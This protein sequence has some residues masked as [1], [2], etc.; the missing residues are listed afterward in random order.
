MAMRGLSRDMSVHLAWQ[1]MR[2]SLVAEGV[3]WSPDVA[4]DLTNRLH[5][6]WHNAL[7]ELHRFGMLDNGDTEVEEDD[8]FGPAPERELQDPHIVKLMEDLAG[9]DG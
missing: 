2:I 6:S 7:L 8:E 1:D 4:K 3:S 9:E 5:E